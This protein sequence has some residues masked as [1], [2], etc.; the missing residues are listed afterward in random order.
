MAKENTKKYVIYN[1]ARMVEGWPEQ[2]EAAQLITTILLKDGEFDRIKYGD[3]T[4]DFGAEDHACGDCAVIKGQYHVQNC[5]IEECP[6]CNGQLLSCDCTIEEEE[7][8]EE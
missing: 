6:N 2:I 4:E 3:E 7:E 8:E 1:G 5:D